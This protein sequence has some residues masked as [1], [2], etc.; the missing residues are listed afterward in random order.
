[1]KM[2]M[3]ILPKQPPGMTDGDLH[4][5]WPEDVRRPGR[6][7]LRRDLKTATDDGRIRREGDGTKRE[8]YRF[9]MLAS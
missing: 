5:A 2:I 1:M 8:P 4:D 7:T 9:S 6:R 3:D